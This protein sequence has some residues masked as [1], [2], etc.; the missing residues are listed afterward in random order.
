MTD[1]VSRSLNRLREM[2]RD[3]L[4]GK[5]EHRE[6]LNKP[7]GLPR[8]DRPKYALVRTGGAS[9][10]Q[11]DGLADVPPV[12]TVLNHHGVTRPR[13]RNRYRDSSCGSQRNERWWRRCVRLA[14]PQY[15]TVP[16]ALYRWCKR[17]PAD[18]LE[19]H[20]RRC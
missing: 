5:P 6:E 4:A 11:P 2:A 19:P 7:R 14:P 20:R 9:L 3:R 13:G 17:Y 16:C 12:E 8:Q 15:R 1:P 18:G 10:R